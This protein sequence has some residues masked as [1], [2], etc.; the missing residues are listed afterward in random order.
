[1]SLVAVHFSFIPSSRAVVAGDDSPL[2]FSFDA[3]I[4]MFLTMSMILLPNYVPRVRLHGAVR[5]T[6]SLDLSGWSDVRVICSTR[7]LHVISII[8]FEA[9]TIIS[10]HEFVRRTWNAL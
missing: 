4:S 6:L 9:V 2:R 7:I 5:I 3:V 1:M 8:R 10:A